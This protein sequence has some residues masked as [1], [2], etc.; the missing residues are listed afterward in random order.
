MVLFDESFAFQDSRAVA[1]C[2]DCGAAKGLSV[3]V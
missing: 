3:V 1:L 2:V